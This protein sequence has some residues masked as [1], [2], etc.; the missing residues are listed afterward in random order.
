[1]R[2][3]LGFLLLSCVSMAA[4]RPNVVL[5]YADDLGYADLGCFGAKAW[6]TPNLDRIAKEGVKFTDFHSAQPVCSASRAALMTGC[7]PNRIGIHGALFPTSQNGIH[8]NELTMAEMLK[9][10]GYATAMV[11][12]WHLGHLPKFLPTKHGFDS[13]LGL[14]YSNDMNPPR[15]PPLPLIDSLAGME[16][17]Y[18]EV[19]QAKLT[20]QYTNRATKFVEENATKPFFLY[21]AHS[22]PHVPLYVGEKF[23]GKS[24][25]GKY[26]DVIEEIDDSVGRILA[27]LDRLKLTENTLIIFTSDNGPWINYG[28]HA[29]SAVPLREGKGTVYEGGVRVPFVARWPGVIPAGKVQ[30]EPAMTIDLLPT[31]AAYTGA[32]LPAH[33]VDGKDI[34]PLF[35]CTDG[36]KCPHDFYAH[37]YHTNEL[38][39][40]RSGPWKLMLPHTSRT[41]QGQKPGADGVAGKYAPEKVTLALYNLT[42]DVGELKNVAEQ[43]PDVVKRLL[44]Y[45][46]KA[47]EDMGDS[48]TKRQGQNTR[49][50]GK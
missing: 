19:D 16:P 5:I 32:K 41:M 1:M 4:E 39:A 23:R 46:E 31:L 24:G 17:R 2:L 8:E 9:A 36:A 12:K 34:L 49:P 28:N 11:G 3:F 37:Y 42:E 22:F 45:A 7:Y 30:M 10:Q 40:I 35:R 25:A 13:Y 33:G 21:F 44:S 47:R 29:G 20:E 43:H 14:P 26:G 18:A 48:L 15:F 27:T 6:K 50:A 38:Q